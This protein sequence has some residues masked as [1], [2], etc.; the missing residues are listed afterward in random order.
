MIK[1]S[2]FLAFFLLVSSPLLR[3]SN[4]PNLRDLLNQDEKDHLSS[5]TSGAIDLAEYAFEMT[6]PNLVFALKAAG[7]IFLASIL[8]NMKHK[9]IP[10]V[11]QNDSFLYDDDDD[12][13]KNGS[14]VQ[15]IYYDN[16]ET[17]T[18][19]LMITTNDQGEK[20]IK[21]R[22]QI[23]IFIEK[24][25]T[26]LFSPIIQNGSIIFSNNS[27]SQ[28]IGNFFIKGDTLL[29]I[30]YQDEEYNVYC[31]P[32]AERL[33]APRDFNQNKKKYQLKIKKNFFEK[34]YHGIEP[35]LNGITTP[36]KFAWKKVRNNPKITFAIA[37]SLLFSLGVHSVKRENNPSFKKWFDHKKRAGEQKVIFKKT[38]NIIEEIEK[39]RENF[40][41]MKSNLEDENFTKWLKDT[42][43]DEEKELLYNNIIKTF[44][45]INRNKNTPLNWE[46]QN[47]DS[48]IT[49]ELLKKILLYREFKNQDF[50]KKRDLLIESLTQWSHQDNLQNKQKKELKFL[51]DTLGNIL[52]KNNIDENTYTQ[53]VKAI[54]LTKEK[55]N[56]YFEKKKQLSA[57]Y[58]FK[59]TS[60]YPKSSQYPLEDNIEAALQEKA[61][62]DTL[63]KGIE[64]RTNTRL[65]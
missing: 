6:K 21:L 60:M 59:P 45:T 20:T 10:I 39:K 50:P 28:K 24:N 9:K 30:T 46:K 15:E 5:R 7:G 14:V 2:L 8:A 17:N 18:K 44:L 1:L 42:P 61:F 49:E 16:D 52:P 54:S 22:D 23:P 19:S 33:E 31:N 26:Y 53:L 62:E 34:I 55:K 4:Y 57:K 56:E 40:N 36:T 27:S 43:I 35:L 13:D 38:E 65:S 63:E 29:F 3:A 12:N 51:M 32:Q 47:N 41:K 58:G 64:S 37:A 25:S 48:K 11:I